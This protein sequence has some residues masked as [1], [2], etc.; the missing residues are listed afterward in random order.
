[1]SHKV[2][3]IL[4]PSGDQQYMNTVSHV[5]TW[6]NNKKIS[7]SFLEKEKNRISDSVSDFK[8]RYITKDSLSD[9]DLILTLGGDGTLIGTCRKV[10]G[11]TPI[12][13][14]NYGKLGFITEFSGHEMFDILDKYIKSE[15]ETK[16]IQ[17]FH[18]TVERNGK[19]V[20]EKRFINDAVFSKNNIARM[21]ELAVESNNK[22]LFN[23]AGD[24]LIISSPL[25]STAYSLAAGGPIVHPDVKGLT[26]TPICPHG[27]THR[28]LII[29][30][31]QSVQ[32]QLLDKHKDVCLT[33]DGQVTFDV[34]PEDKIIISKEEN[35]KVHF[36]VNPN[37]DYF[38][39]LKE[40]FFL[41]K[42]AH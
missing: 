5:V 36:V 12:L 24:G 39:T 17:M 19:K 2:A 9:Q 31:D 22:V 14:V 16:E 8:G 30:D 27:L 3:I 33:I 42:R 21:F 23:V 1:M 34:I 7:Y 4:K 10:F 37:K 13:G 18:I 32:V 15:I 35:D 26:L 25:G 38:L 11:N 28:P 6:F 29:P 40:K 41:S 20:F